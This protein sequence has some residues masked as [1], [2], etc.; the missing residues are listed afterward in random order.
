MTATL[1]TT[2]SAL[3]KG[4]DV[5]G[6]A[7]LTPG[8]LGVWGILL[9]AAGTCIRWWIVGMPE[10]KRAANEGVAADTKAMDSLVTHLTEEVKRLGVMV[11][12]LSTQVV[13]LQHE[14][15]KAEAVIIRM[16]AV[17]D[18]LGETRQIAANI[19]AGDRIAD[20]RKA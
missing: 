8:G 2:A 18:A 1:I 3:S 5:F 11:A 9:F 20:R 13:T 4:N 19:V 12:D 14:L 10:R 6:I 16:K 7:G 17:N 15:A